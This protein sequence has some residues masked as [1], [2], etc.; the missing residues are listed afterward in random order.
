NLLEQ[1]K[2]TEQSRTAALHDLLGRAPQIDVYRVVA[3][4]FDHLGGL[5]H[6]RRIRPEKLRGDGMLV[7][8]EVEITKRLRRAPRDALGAG[9]LRHQQPTTAQ[10]A[11]HAPEQR[12]R[13][14]RHR[15]KDR[16][17]P[18]RQGPNFE[19]SRNHGLSKFKF[20]VLGGLLGGKAEILRI[21]NPLPALYSC[22][23]SNS[24][25]VEPRSYNHSKKVLRRGLHFL[26]RTPFL[27]IVATLKK[28]EIGIHNNTDP[29]T[30]PTIERTPFR[31]RIPS[32]IIC[33]ATAMVFAYGGEIEK[34]SWQRGQ[35]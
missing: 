10:T 15:R 24:P 29:R 34:R 20:S 16:R 33:D 31:V 28:R 13:H 6:D 9:E 1:R 27:R 8:L 14:A 32:A 3:E 12:V 30:R 4:V 35:N 5:G 7:L 11:D 18:Y 17:W 23:L 19:T 21:P 25:G 2:V 22:R 26:R